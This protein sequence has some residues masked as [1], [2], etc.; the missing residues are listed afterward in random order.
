[1]KKPLG[2]EVDLG[3]GHIVLDGNP[4]SPRERGTAA[5]LFSPYLLSLSPI[6]AT[7]ELLLLI[8]C[9][10]GYELMTVHLSII[11]WYSIEIAEH[12][13]I[14]FGV[15]AAVSLPTVCCKAIRVHVYA[16]IRVFPSGTLC[17]TLD[18]SHVL[19]T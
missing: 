10:A 5:P 4:A 9:H 16:K 19:S 6:S 15:G 11:S 14:V 17:Q 7:A 2:T 8:Q 3:P 12:S 1:M 13:K 18:L